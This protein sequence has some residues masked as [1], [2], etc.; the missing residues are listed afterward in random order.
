MFFQRFATDKIESARREKQD[1]LEDGPVYMVKK[2][3]D[4]QRK[5][6]KKAM[7]DWDI[8]ANAGSN[9]GAG[10]DTTAI[11]LSTILYYMYRDKRI[12]KRVRQEIDSLAL[13]ARPSFHEVQKLTYLQ[14]VIKESLRVQ[15]AAGVPLWREVP[16]GGAVICGQFFPEGVRLPMH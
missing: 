3:L 2:F 4:A 9:I 13:P 6:D 10:S 7:T 11:T 8:A 15:P 12:I 14:A 16:K 1:I 5:E